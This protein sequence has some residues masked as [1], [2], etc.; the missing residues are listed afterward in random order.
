MTPEAIIK[1]SLLS[2]KFSQ[3][4][5]LDFELPLSFQ[6]DNEYCKLLADEIKGINPYW[7][8]RKATKTLWRT[9]PNDCGV[10]M[11]VFQ[12]PLS[13]K[14]E[15][16]EIRP[17]HVLYVGRAGDS[18]SQRTLKD[19]YK[20][21]YSKYIG[22]NPAVLWSDQP[23]KTRQE[24]LKKYLTIH[25]LQYWFFSI[26]DRSKISQVEEKLIKILNPPLNVVGKTKFKKG[27]EAPAFKEY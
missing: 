14:A 21:E 18:N 12:S 16:S 24:R 8:V 6:L 22:E 9:L 27:P 23:C 10:Y 15:N 7:E 17:Q 25:P 20:G 2:N 13:M 19:R 26:D 5:C 11:F 3:P 1:Q 4:V